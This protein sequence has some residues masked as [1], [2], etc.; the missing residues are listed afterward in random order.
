MFCILG[1]DA[2][3]C[4]PC[5][6]TSTKENACGAGSGYACLDTNAPC[7]NEYVEASTI[8]TVTVVANSYDIKISE[9][10]G[11]M[12]AGCLP[13]L[14]RDGDVTDAE[15][16]WSCRQSDVPDEKL[17]AITFSFEEALDVRCVQVAF[18]KA[19]ERSRTLEVSYSAA[20]P[21]AVPMVYW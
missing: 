1:F 14:T 10:F 4:C 7:F 17:C 16:R 2:G 13:G 6:C 19:G 15:S 8:T 18:W 21:G 12:D 11:C 5:T 9:E 3:D 20:P